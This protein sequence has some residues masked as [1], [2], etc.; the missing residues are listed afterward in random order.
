MILKLNN[1]VNPRRLRKFSSNWEIKV[2]VLLFFIALAD[3]KGYAQGKETLSKRIGPDRR[4]PN[5]AVRYIA[6]DSIEILVEANKFRK[7]LRKNIRR[8]DA[9]TYVHKN[10][11]LL[12]CMDDQIG[13]GNNLND[14][15][16][17]KDTSGIYISFTNLIENS[18]ANLLKKGDVYIKTSEGQRIDMVRYTS[19]YD[20]GRIVKETFYIDDRM[21][22]ERQVLFVDNWNFW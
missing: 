16:G 19:I 12:T 18:V 13:N 21:F 5:N 17:C 3:W 9:Y 2:L 7:E 4:Y 1:Q 11:Q 8:I 15:G 10:T 20:Q 14:V 6:S 22:F